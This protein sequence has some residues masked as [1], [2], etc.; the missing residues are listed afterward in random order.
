MTGT[1]PGNQ[2]DTTI[3]FMYKIAFHTNL[4]IGEA[5]AL[6]VLNVVF[7]LIVVGIYLR[8]AHFG[9]LIDDV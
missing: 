6:G 2:A 7:I 5:S 4:D 8:F 1:Q 3:T 9:K